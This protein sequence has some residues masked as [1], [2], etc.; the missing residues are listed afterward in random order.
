MNAKAQIVATIGPSSL[1]PDTLRQM[2]SA[3]MNLARLNF[4]W[5]KITEADARIELLRA[6][7]KEA[8]VSLPII[9]D[10]PGPRV[11]LKETHTYATPEMFSITDDDI[12]FLDL[13][14]R[15]EVEYVALSFVGAATDIEYCKE[16]LNK[17]GGAQKIIAKIE[18]KIAADAIDSIISAADAIMIAR[19]D[20]GNEIPLEDIPFVQRMILEKANKAGKPAITATQ[21]MLSMTEHDTPTRAEVSDVTDAILEGSDAVMLSEETASG[22]YPVLAVQMMER[23]VRDTQQHTPTRTYNSL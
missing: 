14:V 15:K 12:T 22:R 16:L 6:L 20:L 18:R 21:M 19:G 8:A 4:A 11:Q 3:G 1:E 10:L 9:A 13:C 2:I 7:A 5:E 17:K 23:I